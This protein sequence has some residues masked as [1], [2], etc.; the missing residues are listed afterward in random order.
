MSGKRYD[1]A[2]KHQ[3]IK[4]IREDEKSASEVSKELG[5]H[6]KTIYPWLDEERQDGEQSFPGK[7]KLKSADEEMRRLKKENA[8]LRE[9]NEILRKA[10]VIFAKHHK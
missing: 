6:K 2:F 3:A 10:A 4:K 8:N 5:L 9:V 7:G 1:R